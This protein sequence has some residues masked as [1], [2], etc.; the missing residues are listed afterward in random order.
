MASA[1][2]FAEQLGKAISESA[3]ALALREA[4]KAMNAQPEILA[5][6]KDYQSHAH[7]L[8]ELEHA[9][10]P[11]EVAD[12]HKLQELQQKLLAFDAFK[13]FTAKQVDYVD[14]MRQVNDVI[15]KH[16]TGTERD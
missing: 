5:A 14:L 11:I 15:R 16:L 6:L 12:K 10:K 7:K 13:K 8:G 4:R 1:L 9:G 3:Q 2:E